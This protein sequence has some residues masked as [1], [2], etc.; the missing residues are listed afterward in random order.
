MEFDLQ[1][2]LKI[3]ESHQQRSSSTHEILQV[4]P[5]ILKLA[6]RNSAS[7]K[8][9]RI[10]FLALVHGDEI[11]GL[12][13]LN[14]LIRQI[15]NQD[16][17]T[18]S[19]IY[20]AL[21]NI[22]A[23]MSGKRFLEEDLNRSFGL[24]SEGSIESR[25]ARELEK[26]MLNHCDYLIDIHQTAEDTLNAFF[27][28]QYSSSRCLNFINEINPGIPTIVQL[29]TI[30]GNTGLASDEYV[31]SRGGFGT[32]IEAGR[33]GY[34]REYFDLCFSACRKTL[35]TLQ[36][37]SSFLERPEGLTSFTGLLF[38]ISSRFQ[39]SDLRMQLKPGWKNLASIK[40]GEVVGVCGNEEIYS[41]AS[42]YILFPK[43]QA[44]DRIGQSLFFIC[45]PVR[46]LQLE[47]APE[48]VAAEI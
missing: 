11:L 7:V 35:Q 17:I 26:L 34:S 5:S 45:T 28:F 46:P 20:F 42:G 43:Y 4:G 12:P 48:L 3:F 8:G 30:G 47:K 23:A 13:V 22:P 2:E 6:P 36:R 38:Q 37:P 29:D 41:P 9:P 44:A 10:G 32:T 18:N 19:E 16:I 27:I 15:L 39:V 14:Q 24:S 25:R 31:R 40:S 21:G 1:G 33:I